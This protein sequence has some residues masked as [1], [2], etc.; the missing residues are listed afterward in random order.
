MEEIEVE[1]I[2][3]RRDED[4]EPVVLGK[5]LEMWIDQLFLALNL[6]TTKD[7]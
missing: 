4:S 2:E 7:A 3:I 6:N 1:Y 5:E